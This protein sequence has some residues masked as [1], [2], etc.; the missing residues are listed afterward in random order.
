MC[1][2]SISYTWDSLL[3]SAFGVVW[4]GGLSYGA[5]TPAVDRVA[6]VFGFV[7][8]FFLWNCLM[9]FVIYVQHTHPASPGTSGAT[10]VGER[11][12]RND[13]VHIKLM[14]PS[15][16][17]P[18]HSRARRPPREMG[19]PSTASRAQAR[20][21]ATLDE[22]LNS[23]VLPGATTGIPCGAASCTISRSMCDRFRRTH[24]LG[25]VRSDSLVARV[26]PGANRRYPGWAPKESLKASGAPK[27]APTD[28][29]ECRP[30]PWRLAGRRSTYQYSAALALLF[31]ML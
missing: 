7:V 21:T 14:R 3:V 16:F 24:H 19:I 17:D 22:R 27:W 29:C 15:T 20:L 18:L 10:S 8:P 25:A 1:P 26:A 4:V 2:P 5:S 13:T 9:G 31:V 23:E 11:G 6:V 28:E 30:Y 12:L